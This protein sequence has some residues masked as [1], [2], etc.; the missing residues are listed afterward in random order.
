LK[1]IFEWRTLVDSRLV[2]PS[3]LGR[4]LEQKE[5][6]RKGIGLA[7]EFPE[8]VLL[9]KRLVGLPC[10]GQERGELKDQRRGCGHER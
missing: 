4:S 6:G 1:P 10:Q 2:H 9:S 3:A 8:S 7:V 5:K